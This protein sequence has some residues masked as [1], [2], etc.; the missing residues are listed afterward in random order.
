MSR[1][2]HLIALVLL[3]IW[4]PA[5]M[6]CGLEGLFEGSAEMCSHHDTTGDGE[7]ACD[8][9]AIEDGSFRTTPHEI[10]IAPPPAL[11]WWAV[12]DAIRVIAPVDPLDTWREEAAPPGLAR[13][14]QFGERAALPANAPSV[15]S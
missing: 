8:H 11:A 2:R 12:A 1:F 15:V 3:A 14:W 6:H 13:T 5:T 10:V 4:V 7:V 9:L